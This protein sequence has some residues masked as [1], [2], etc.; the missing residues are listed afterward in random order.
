MVR[1]GIS[2]IYG[3]ITYLAYK[4]KNDPFKIIGP[5]NKFIHTCNKFEI[6]VRTLKLAFTDT[7][8][9]NLIT[10]LHRYKLLALQPVLF[11]RTFND[12]DTKYCQCDPSCSSSRLMKR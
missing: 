5:L 3:N 12:T 2:F 8:T 4:F 10:Y 11:F 6:V 7:N 1:N 9:D